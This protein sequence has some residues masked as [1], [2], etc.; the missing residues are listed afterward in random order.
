MSSETKKAIP[1]ILKMT[2]KHPLFEKINQIFDLM[3]DLGVSFSIDNGHLTITDDES[4]QDWN[5]YDSS[6]APESGHENNFTQ[7][8]ITIDFGL[9]RVNQKSE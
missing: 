2:D 9:Y 6:Y 5:V 4:K 3:D 8:P 7:L 1:R